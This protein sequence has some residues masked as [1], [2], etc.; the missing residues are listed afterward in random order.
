M[1]GKHNKCCCNCQIGFDN[2]N[3]ADATTLGPKWTEDGSGLWGIDS[4]VAYSDTGDAIAMFNVA[5]RKG[6]ESMEA[7]YEIVDEVED[8][9][10]YVLVNVKDLNNYHIA[11]FHNTAVNPKIELGKV[12]GGVY[13]MLKE[14]NIIG[15]TLPYA[16]GYMPRLCRR[17]YARIAPDEFCAG[18][19]E[20]TLSQ[21]TVTPEIITDG[22]YSGMGGY[23]AT[24][25]LFYDNFYFGEHLWTNPQCPTCICQCEDEVVGEELVVTISDTTNRMTEAEGCEIT[26]NWDRVNGY[27]EGSATCCDFTW[28]IRLTCPSSGDPEEFEILVIQGCNDSDTDT[29]VPGYIAKGHRS[30]LDSSTCDPFYLRFGPFQTTI[31][32]LLCACGTPMVDPTGVYYLEVTKAP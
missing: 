27:W 2:F 26:I 11:K 25:T 32:D 20:A 19:R 5:H 15:K 9:I 17:F 21:V 6:D 13:T 31:N 18:I 29:T 12:V 14:E 30:A 1:P 22:I 8:A 24:E 28:I 4:N 10:Y 16:C 7:Y 3:R 23:H